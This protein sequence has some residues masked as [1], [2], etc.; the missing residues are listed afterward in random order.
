MK[1]ADVVAQTRIQFNKKQLLQLI[2]HY[3]QNEGYESVASALQKEASLPQLP[4][5]ITMGPPSRSSI[6][7]PS[8]VRPV[9][10]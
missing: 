2:Q 4:Q 8:T 10:H 5:P 9:S 6:S 7:T 1:Q 3:L